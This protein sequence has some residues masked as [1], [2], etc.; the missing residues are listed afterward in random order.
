MDSFRADMKD[1]IAALA[2]GWKAR[3][4]TVIRGEETDSDMEI[5]ADSKN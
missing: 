3:Q 4:P 5:V 2:R 1:E